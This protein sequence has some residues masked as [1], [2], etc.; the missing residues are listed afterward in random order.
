VSMSSRLLAG[1]YAPRLP[2]WLWPLAPASLIFR[3]LVALRR[4]GYRSG[5]LRAARMPV[6]VCVIGNVTVG[7]TGKTPL[8]IAL[9]E[10]L[11]ARGWRPGLV[12]RGYRAGRQEPRP[13][14]QWSSCEDA[15]DEALLLAA[16]GFPVWAGRDRVAAAQGLVRQHPEVNLLLCD[17]GLQHYALRRDVELVV[18]DA[19]RGFGNGWLLPAGPLREPAARA[20]EAAAV[21]WHAGA[22]ALAP[23]DARWIM[24]LEGDEFVQVADS[25]RRARAPEFAGKR[26][27][28]VAGIGNPQRFFGYLAGLG[29]AAQTHAFPDHHRY[30][31]GDL[32]FPEADV[33]LLTAKDAVKCRGQI[34]PRWWV[35]PV[36]A[37]IPAELIECIEEKLRGSKT[38]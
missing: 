37:K 15:G 18:V 6:P 30:S 23:A 4:A 10:M 27:V 1:W 2:L 38:A 35:L 22:E 36:R 28:A 19:T 9:A 12:T 33:I 21:V 3:V 31:R 34:D 17:D 32:A 8:T 25:R 13:V 7:G 20:A 14:E 11:A 5:F 26:V 24:R 29:V 16:A